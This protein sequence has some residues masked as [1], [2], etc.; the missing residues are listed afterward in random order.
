MNEWL[1]ARTPRLAAHGSGPVRAGLEAA[2]AAVLRSSVRGAE[3]LLIRRAERAG[4][5]WSGQISLPGG[6][7]EPA[8]ADLASTALR[9]TFEEVGLDL[10]RHARP[11][12]ALPARH[13][14]AAGRRLEMTITPFVFELTL[15][16]ALSPSRDEVAETFWFPLEAAVDGR[17]DALHPVHHEG[18]RFDL[19]CWRFEDRTIWGLT[20]AMLSELAGYATTENG[21]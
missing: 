5:R 18:G 4:D 1:A 15:D 11:L 9:E 21:R 14:V 20:H 6:R 16:P 7:A 2:V 13:A 19:P 12:G 3:V 8:D 17:W 10:A